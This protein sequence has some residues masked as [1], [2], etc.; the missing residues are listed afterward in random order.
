MVYIMTVIL[1]NFLIAKVSSSYENF[2]DTAIL[3]RYKNKIHFVREY[4]LYKNFI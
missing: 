4:M 3:S 2:L 1:N